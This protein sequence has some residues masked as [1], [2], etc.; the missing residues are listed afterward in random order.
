MKILYQIE[1]LLSSNLDFLVCNEYFVALAIALGTRA[2][3][4]YSGGG[5]KITQLNHLITCAEVELRELGVRMEFEH[6]VIIRQ[7][8]TNGHSAEIELHLGNGTCSVRNLGHADEPWIRF[9]VQRGESFQELQQRFDI[10]ARAKA[11]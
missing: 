2:L 5:M 4:N 9:V 11:A 8:L 3:S 10:A 6:E 7:A 1:W